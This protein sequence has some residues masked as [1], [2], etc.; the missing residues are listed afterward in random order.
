MYD[1]VQSDAP[2]ILGSQMNKEIN[3]TLQKDES[4]PF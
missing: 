2:M 3:N 4:A 1:A